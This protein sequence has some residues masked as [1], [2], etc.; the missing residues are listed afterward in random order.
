MEH[1]AEKLDDG[2]GGFFDKLENQVGQAPPGAAKLAAE[3]F[4]LLYLI[5]FPG[6]MSAGTKRAQI[7]KVW[8]WSGEPFPEE[9]WALGDVL[10][11][12]VVNTGTAYNTVP[13]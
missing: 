11:E 1:Y 4:W 6:S 10:E 8:R 7:R 13:N 5:M 3:M 12:G 9:S 2:P